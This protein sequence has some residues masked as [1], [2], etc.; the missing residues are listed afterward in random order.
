M[1]SFLQP[2]EFVF[3]CLFWRTHISVCLPRLFC[4]K[5]K[6]IGQ[7]NGVQLWL[8]T[9]GHRGLWWE[10]TSRKQRRG[11][12]KSPPQRDRDELQPLI[13]NLYLRSSYLAVSFHLN[14]SFYCW[15]KN[16]TQRTSWTIQKKMPNNERLKMSVQSGS[17]EEFSLFC[18]CGGKEGNGEAKLLICNFQLCC[19]EPICIL[20]IFQGWGH[21]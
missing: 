10:Q 16:H 1:E 20:Y 2:E 7:V 14:F 5:T 13:N 4:R 8:V 21:F 3:I 17:L 12:Q 11:W 9:Y 6:Y 15:K 19:R 18:K